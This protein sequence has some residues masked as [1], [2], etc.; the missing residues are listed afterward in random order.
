MSVYIF[1]CVCEFVC[2]K[3]RFRA[4]LFKTL[5]GLSNTKALLL[6]IIRWDLLWKGQMGYERKV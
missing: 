1:V 3:Q 2:D 6:E 4:Y 5:P